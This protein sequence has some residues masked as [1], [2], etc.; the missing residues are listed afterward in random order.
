MV[1]RA[2]QR[3]VPDAEPGAEWPEDLTAM[4]FLPDG[5]LVPAAALGAVPLDLAAGDAMAQLQAWYATLTRTGAQIVNTYQALGRPIPCAL[6]K[7]HNAA[8]TVYLRTGM[9]VF[10]Q[11]LRRG[12]VPVQKMLDR[13]GNVLR[14]LQIASPVLP[15]SFITTDCRVAGVTP[16]SPA[17]S[18]FGSPLVL[19][20]GAVA[21][22]IVLIG[23]AAAIRVAWPGKD[24]QL[25]A[26]QASVDAY[27]K[28]VQDALAAGRKPAE[29]DTIC[30]PPV[31]AP[32]PEG[33]GLGFW[34]TIGMGAALL[35]A[36]GAGVYLAMRRE[37]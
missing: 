5:R 21:I 17:A 26:Y 7:R 31:P 8:V 2:P 11:L 28:C 10:D 35:A 33:S 9:A 29:L 36:G 12:V 18:A 15:L 3:V 13:N 23:V 37:S 34:A 16:L 19:I 14:E 27:A 24:P 30:H 1:Y 6:R 22:V 4:K 25:A 20:A 32:P